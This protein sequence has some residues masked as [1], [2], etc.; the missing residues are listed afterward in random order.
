L[1]EK[2]DRPLMVRR[3]SDILSPFVGIAEQNMAK[4]FREAGQEQAVLLLDEADT[5]LRDRNGAT[6]NWEVSEVN[7]MLT[8]MES[9]TG[10]FIASTNLMGSLDAAALRR[11]DM[12]V[13]FDYLKSGQAWRLFLDT[14]A[15]FN[16]EPSEMNRAAL[17]K[18]RLLTPGDFA[19]VVRQS[20]LRKIQSAADLVER[21]S[22]ECVVKPEGLKQSIGF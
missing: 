15:K 18:L 21:L 17:D 2:L 7:E 1:A 8:Q 16:I 5:F 20:R 11:F 14:A 6:R 12:K 4:M 9:F 10:I 13:K 22:A 3:A 19:N